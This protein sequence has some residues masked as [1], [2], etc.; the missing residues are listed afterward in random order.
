MPL[1]SVK[2][3]NR[4]QFKITRV[5]I[6]ASALALAIISVSVNLV[7]H[8]L[9]KKRLVND[10]TV[11]SQIIANRSIASLIFY[12]NQAA[13]IN[14]AVGR[15]HHSIETLCLYDS[16]GVFF[17]QYIQNGLID[18]CELTFK[19]LD[20]KAPQSAFVDDN[21]ELFLPILDADETVG[22]LSLRSNL[23]YV[24][25]VQAYLLVTNTVVMVIAI[26]LALLLASR[27]L[28]TV[29]KPLHDLHK[30]ASAIISN[31]FSSLRATKRN[32]DEIGL[33]VSAFNQMLDSLAK[34]NK[35]LLA[36]QSRFKVLAQNA[37]IGI[38]AFDRVNGHIFTNTKWREITG[39][40]RFTTTEQYCENIPESHQNLY[41]R[42]LQ[43]VLSSK[44]SQMLE[45]PYID[46]KTGRELN[47]IEYFAPQLQ[48]QTGEVTSII[49]SVVDATELKNAQN[50][51]EKLAFYDPLTQLPNRRF[52]K[53][54]LHFSLEQ[55]RKQKQSIA[56]LMLDLDHFKKVNDSLGHDA[57]D[58]LLVKLAKC[59]RDAVF[60]EDVVS[61]MGGDEFM[62]LLQ[63]AN[64]KAS[65]ELVVDRIFQAIQKPISVYSQNFEV[66]ASIGVAVYPEDASLSDTLVKNADIALYKAKDNGRNQVAYF[67]SDLDQELKEVVRLERKLRSAIENES[68]AIYVQ[69]QF[70]L[71]KNKFVWGEALLR[72]IDDEEGFIPP[73]KF[74]PIAEES[75][76]IITIGQ[77]V[78]EQVCATLQQYEAEFAE[79]GIEGIA[80]NL[81]ARQFFSTHLVDDIHNALNRYNIQPQQIEFE[82]TESLVME[83]I[84]KA[85]EIMGALRDIGCKLSIDD[86]GTGYSSLAYLKQFP[87]HTVKIDRSFIM[88]IPDDKNDVEI[89]SAII[90]M[91][92]KLG[93]QTVAEGVETPEHFLFL[94]Q[95]ACDYIQGYLVARPMP[96]KDLLNLKTFV[97]ER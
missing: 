65:I 88:G 82:L 59:L 20:V 72:W 47:L 69:P 24:E 37:P 41:H 17:S 7:E 60:E 4:F 1:S 67:S 87:I 45:Y 70:D 58:E 26:L 5:V 11:I 27:M 25:N 97:L 90:A 55:A 85:I 52:F 33:L 92:H 81:S 78:I 14:L 6:A 91:A 62:I 31:P 40:D 51:L 83:D 30:T 86:F 44:E 42:C 35:A 66:S 68:L 49:G 19:A 21:V 18:S 38:Y 54:H 57:G 89:S 39:I 23:N 74:I 75:G 76:L 13:D 28:K 15:F 64:E 46:P 43:K 34:E 77:W 48:S 16:S 93:L 96:I 2:R 10:L 12:D 95:Q 29:L 8:S 32:D 56:V 9:A 50:E 63:N 73:D 3:F 36:S 84:H 71:A 94:Q 22:Y 61:R 80:I 53:D 79:I